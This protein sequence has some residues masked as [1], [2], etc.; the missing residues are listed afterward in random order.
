MK[1]LTCTAA[2]RRLHQYHDGALPVADQIDVWAHLDWC[3]QCAGVLADM[4]VLR[5]ALRGLTRGQEPLTLEE[6]DSLQSAVVSRIGAEA[7]TA[8]SVRLS[9]MFDVHLVYAGFGA[10]IATAAT[11]ILM[12]S[13]MQFDARGRTPE[14]APGSNEN[15][16]VADGRMLLPRALNDVLMTAKGE[17]DDEVFTLSAV[18]TREGRIVNLELHSEDGQ[19][20][21]V[22]TSE[23]REMRR[24]LG[25]VS[26]ARFEPA[27][28]AGLPVAVNMVW[29]VAHM[30][31]HALK[32]P[33]VGVP[34]TTTRK[35]RASGPAPP[36]R[37]AVYVI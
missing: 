36:S 37:T 5:S 8:L 1:V 24:L 2:R 25:E 16:M 11:V 6:G 18:V 35:R 28:A 27:R 29:M 20:L 7:S 19:A 4:Q 12:L 26:R 14:Q 34:S 21:A 15:P 17:G 23:S 22:D 30:T 33:A 9:A 10:V 31:V 13:L 32:T 3:D